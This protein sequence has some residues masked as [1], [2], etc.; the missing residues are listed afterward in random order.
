[1][2]G[3]QLEP[4]V[5]PEAW[6]GSYWTAR[7]TAHHW[8]LCSR[9]QPTLYNHIVNY[10][11]ACSGL[12]GNLYRIG[13]S[14]P[15]GVG[16]AR[17]YLPIGSPSINVFNASASAPISPDVCSTSSNDRRP[18]CGAAADSIGKRQSTNPHVALG[19]QVLNAISIDKE[20]YG[21]LFQRE[22]FVVAAVMVGRLGP[23]L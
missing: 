5:S 7:S 15:A 13:G 23:T 8:H 2:N 4:G 9:I 3:M 22:I 20:R 16:I 1:M 14:A 11:N 17:R 6:S 19:R 12:D 21:F 10:R 18:N